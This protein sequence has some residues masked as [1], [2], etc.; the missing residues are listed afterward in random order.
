VDVLFIRTSAPSNLN[1]TSTRVFFNLQI[2]IGTE[3][4]VVGTLNKKEFKLNKLKS[5]MRQ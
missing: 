1:F 3:T 4:S 5:K 2:K